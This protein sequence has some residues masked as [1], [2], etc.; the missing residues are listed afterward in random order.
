MSRDTGRLIR[1][2]VDKAWNRRFSVQY[3]RALTRS[4]SP[5]LPEDAGASEVLR[6]RIHFA[7]VRPSNPW[8]ERSR[9][10]AQA[11]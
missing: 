5:E 2:A 10:S 1:V 8:S 9:N 11:S 7:K 3:V 4:R 6:S